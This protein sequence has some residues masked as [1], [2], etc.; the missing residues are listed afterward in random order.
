MLA[1]ELMRDS[2]ERVE[3]TRSV[4]LRRAALDASHEDKNEHD[5]EDDAQAARWP[6]T[7]ISTISPTRKCADKSKNHKDD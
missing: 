2:H 6:I 7:P 4:F 3:N 5:Q 1:Q